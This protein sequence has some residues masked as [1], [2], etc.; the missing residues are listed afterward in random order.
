MKRA[1]VLGMAIAIGQGLLAQT[2]TQPPNQTALQ[3]DP[4]TPAPNRASGE[5]FGPLQDDGGARGDAD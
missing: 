4:L 3:R 5:G 1:I 2:P